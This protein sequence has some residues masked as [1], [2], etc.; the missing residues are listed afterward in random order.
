MVHLGVGCSFKICIYLLLHCA[1]GPNKVNWVDP[2]PLPPIPLCLSVCSV[3]SDAG[4]TDSMV[5]LISMYE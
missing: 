3:L 4:E 1:S 2:P 5:T